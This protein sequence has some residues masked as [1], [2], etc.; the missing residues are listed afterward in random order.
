MRLKISITKLVIAIVLAFLGLDVWFALVYLPGA[1]EKE[2]Q[3]ER[4]K[5]IDRGEKLSIADFVSEKVPA[6]RNFFADPLWV[7]LHDREPVKKDGMTYQKSRKPPGESQLDVLQ[8]PFSEAEKKALEEEF[9]AFAPL[10]GKEKKL[11]V[12]RKHWEA[13]RKSGNTTRAARFVLEALAPSDPVISR[14]R[15]LGERPESYY[16]LAYEDGPAMS[17]EHVTPMLYASQWLQLHG[18]T[19]LALGRTDEAFLDG[20]LMFRLAKAL[21]PERTL[22]VVLVD[23][24]IVN[25]AAGVVRQGIRDHSWNE[26]QLVEFD[27]DLARI[28]LP[29]RLAGGLRAERALWLD[30]TI[31]LVLKGGLDTINGLVGRDERTTY[32]KVMARPTFWI[33][34]TYWLPGDKT[35]YAQ[36]IQSWVDTLEQV[37]SEGMREGFFPNFAKEYREDNPSGWGSLRR[38][39][40]VLSLPALTGSIRK[41]ARVQTDVSQTR[42]A[43]ALERYRMKHGEYPEKLDAVVPEFLEKLPLDLVTMEPFLYRREASGKFMLWSIG[44]DEIDDDGTPGKKDDEGDWVWAYQAGELPA[45]EVKKEDGDGTTKGH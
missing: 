36:S 12:L 34:R 44:W 19:L 8:R 16:P 2:W 35:F 20:Q 11:A 39:M 18:M 1:A 17:L 42:I 5:L 10:D 30:V 40:S 13:A 6:E 45:K 25:L 15:E 43:I 38:L 4:Q 3:A 29:R 37:P 9:P 33:Y 24:T 21:E 7:E 31:P 14:L 22:I 23:M 27:S 26:A 28:D 41:A 32:Q